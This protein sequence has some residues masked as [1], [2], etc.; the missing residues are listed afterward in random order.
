M[1]SAVVAMALP[2][3]AGLAPVVERVVPAPDRPEVEPVTPL[4]RLASVAALWPLA[5]A[6]PT[7]PEPPAA[8]TGANGLAAGAG[9]RLARS[10][11]GAV[12][13]TPAAA[14]VVLSSAAG[15][16]SCNW[17]AGDLAVTAEP[18]AGGTMT[19]SRACGLSPKTGSAT[20]TT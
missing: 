9:V 10:R 8:V 13:F 15:A 19:L 5:A 20:I 7:T 16:E 14:P 1:R 17:L 4:D 12:S 3:W 6:A 2:V 18:E 11:A